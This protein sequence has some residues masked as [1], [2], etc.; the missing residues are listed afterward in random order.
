LIGWRRHARSLVGRTLVQV[1]VRIGIVVAVASLLGYWHV[2]ESLEAQALQQLATY[3]KE[4]RARESAIFILAGEHLRT[5]AERY[6][7]DYEASF[8]RSDTD[9]AARFDRLFE[10]HAD[11][12]VR[13]G[14]DAF[15]QYGITGAIGP[16]TVVNADLK[17]RLV[18]AF[19]S[20]ARFG[21]AWRSRFVNLYAITPEHAAL[22]YWP[23]QPW[24]LA[25]SDWEISGKLA[26]VSAA[27]G[28]VVVTGES[29]AP[30]GGESVWS[31]LYYDY[32]VNDWLVSTAEPV[33]AGDRHLLSVGHDIL[34]HEL[35]ERVL[36]SE[37]DD[38]VNLVLDLGKGDDARLIA[39]P[40]FM[41]AIQANGGSLS[42]AATGDP[43]LMRI[44]GFARSRPADRIIVENGADDEYLAITPLQGP[45]WVL[46]T[47]FPQ[48]IIGRQAWVAARIILLL[49]AAALLVEIA[50][51][52]MVLKNQVARPL[53][54]LVEATGQV[55]S[56]RLHGAIADDGDDELGDLARSFNRMAHE[57]EAREAALSERSQ[58]LASVNERLACELRERREMEATL[59]RQREELHQSEK[60]KALGSLLSGIAH[61]LNNPLSVVVGRSVLLEEKLR[62]SA[63]QGAAEKL[64]TA[65]ERCARIVRTFLAMA[66]Q[67]APV[68]QPVRLGDVVEAALELFASRLRS[69]GVTVQVAMPEDL[70]EVLGDAGQLGQVFGNLLVNAQ[71]AMAG[72]PGDHRIRI[73]GGTERGG[74]TVAIRVEDSGPGIPPEIRHRLFEPF[75]TT[76]PAGVGT[77]MG[78]SVCWRIV[79]LHGGSIR[80][81]TAAGGG[82]AFVVVLPLPPA[83]M[84][85]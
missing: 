77:G 56:G 71:Q 79:E 50:I 55:A 52:Y 11:G 22:M 43:H 35:L 74:G 4:R 10:R 49:G 85:G 37:I 53:R 18:V 70:P 60:I 54:R 6:R 72:Q 63:Q 81:E 21:P 66:R 28:S 2:R 39:H 57:V 83:S 7:V 31:S 47:V 76:K 19:D 65:A 16:Y 48:A 80:L 12:G 78:L 75:F 3:V 23:D 41:D 38:T 68:R 42:V 51:L 26:L 5:F 20:L 17:R 33:V 67:Q 29:D 32:G 36:S 27:R 24:A 9:I 46:V 14:E 82:A 58:A 59:V 69:A 15:H 73:T 8:A 44:A 64:R 34:L 62:G 30:P 1:A 61:E 25:A 13:L 84:P 45:G 40:R